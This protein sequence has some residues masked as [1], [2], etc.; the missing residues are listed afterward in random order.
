MHSV[1]HVWVDCAL[2]AWGGGG[3]SL[4]ASRRQLALRH[5]VVLFVIP[6]ARKHG[7]SAK[8]QGEAPLTD[9][10]QM[11]SPVIAVNSDVR[12]DVVVDVAQ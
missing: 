7:Y 11:G 2:G 4:T 9:V 8:E 1:S 5:F 3:G 6:R 10:H 12:G